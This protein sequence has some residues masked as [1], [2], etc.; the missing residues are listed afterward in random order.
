MNTLTNSFG[1]QTD[2]T[3]FANERFLNFQPSKQHT[4]A[5]YSLMKL[6][7]ALLLLFYVS[8]MNAF[9]ADRGLFASIDTG[10]LIYS[11]APES[12]SAGFRIG[13]G[14]QFDRYAGMEAGFSII[15]DATSGDDCMTYIATLSTCP[16]ENLSASSSQVAVVGTL[17]LG[18]NHSLFGKLG[19]A[20]TSL[21]YS[22]SYTPCFLVFCDPPITGS[23][24]TTKTNRMFGIGWQSASLQPFYWRVQYEN[25]GKIKMTVNYDNQPS[26]TFDIVIQFISVGFVY[27]F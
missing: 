24:S 9:A 21:D 20:T 26:K 10:M 6:I 27:K 23:G 16:K 19:W 22:Y 1:S 8:S 18:E 25:F 5:G 4:Q 11:N 3:T 12:S 2:P 13:G 7:A 15:D 17:P 14:Y